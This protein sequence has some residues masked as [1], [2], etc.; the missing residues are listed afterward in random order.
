MLVDSQPSLLLPVRAIV[1]DRR[2]NHHASRRRL[3][4]FLN[5]R[6]VCPVR[7]TD[8]EVEDMNATE[9]SKVEGVDEP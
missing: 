5:K 4:Y 2:H 1:A 9:H 6:R 7:P 3:L 8:T